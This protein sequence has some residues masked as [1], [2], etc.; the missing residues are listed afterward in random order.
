MPGFVRWQFALVYLDVIV[1]FSKSSADHIK[2]VRRV[3]LL[4]YEAVVT[5]KPKRCK[6]FAETIDYLYHVNP[7]GRLKPARH[8]TDDVAK[9]EDPTT[10]TELP[11]FHCLSMAF[12]WIVWKFAHLIARVN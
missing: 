4:F 10:Q 11:S 12:R 1:V 3:S 9:L 2:Q 6:F 5:L 8:T 7:N